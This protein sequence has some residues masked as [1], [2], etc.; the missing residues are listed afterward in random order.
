MIR[1]R[2]FQ[3][4]TRYDP[5]N[6]IA[7]AIHGDDEMSAWMRGRVV[8]LTCQTDGRQEWDTDLRD[9]GSDRVPRECLAAPLN[10]ITKAL[11]TRRR[12]TVS[13]YG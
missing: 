13:W 1:H 11:W 4:A 8:D 5:W 12:R 10:N 9:A 3:H 7:R 6:S 2:I